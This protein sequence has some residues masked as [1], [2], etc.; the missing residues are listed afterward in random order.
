MRTVV[1]LLLAACSSAPS[2]SAPGLTV[3]GVDVNPPSGYGHDTAATNPAS[4]PGF[5]AAVPPMPSGDAGH[6]VSQCDLTGDTDGGPNAH[7]PAVCAAAGGHCIDTDIVDTT[8]GGPPGG[9]K[10]LQCCAM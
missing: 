3:T 5:D 6:C 8:P 1:L 4:I 7:L 9:G 10:Y 2:T